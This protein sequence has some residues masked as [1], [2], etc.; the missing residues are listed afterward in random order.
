MVSTPSLP[1]LTLMQAVGREQLQCGGQ[2]INDVNTLTEPSRIF[3]LP[4]HCHSTDALNSVYFVL[5][6]MPKTVYV[7]NN[8]GEWDAEHCVGCQPF[9]F[10]ELLQVLG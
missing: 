5:I 1:D 6:C 9:V 2:E 10:L 7:C 8:D 4:G 3:K